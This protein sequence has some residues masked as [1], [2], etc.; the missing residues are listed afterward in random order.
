MRESKLPMNLPPRLV[1]RD[2]AA[3][4]CGMTG[5]TFAELVKEG[6]MPSPKKFRTRVL[7]DIRE[8]DRAI[9]GERMHNPW[10]AV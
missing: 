7:W 5:N 8:I 2:A 1:S 10:D 4:Y 3:Q 6:K 9:D